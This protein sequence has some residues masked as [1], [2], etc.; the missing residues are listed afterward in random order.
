M[1]SL[2]IGIYN[3][4]PNWAP[5]SINF[6]VDPLE[7][8]DAQKE[9]MEGKLGFLHLTGEE[10][11]FAID[12]QHRVAGI[13]KALSDRSVGDSLANDEVSVIFVSHDETS[14]EGKKRTRRLFTTVNKKAKRVSK[15][16]EIALDEDNGFAIVTRNMINDHWLFEDR[17][18][19][20]SYASTA[21]ISQNDETSITSVIGLYEIIKELY[22]GP[23]KKKFES[24]RPDDQSIIEFQGFVS[25]YLNILIENCEQLNTALLQGNMSVKHYREDQ[26]HLLFRPVGQRVFARTTRLLVDRNQNLKESI[27]SMLCA[28]MDISSRQWHN[29]LWNPISETIIAKN[30]SL[31]ET[32]LLRLIGEEARSNYYSLKL[33]ERLLARDTAV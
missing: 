21:A 2:I 20:I 14:L 32:Q 4:N 30:T 16:A 26:N 10:K 27:L 29:I 17:R 18:R 9:S 23:N 3:G 15:A 12:G 11:L 6:S 5:L 24:T 31:A 22:G 1:G 25:D 19:H 33:D 7:V 28:E 8:S 13:K